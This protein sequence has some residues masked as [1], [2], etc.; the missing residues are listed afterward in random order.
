MKGKEAKGDLE[1]S[2]LFRTLRI[3]SFSL[4]SLE[5]LSVSLIYLFSLSFQDKRTKSAQ[6]F[7]VL[8]ITTQNHHFICLY[9]HSTA[10]SL[11]Y[12]YF[13]WAYHCL[14][15]AYMG[16]I[17]RKAHNPRPHLFY[18]SYSSPNDFAWERK[19]SLAGKSGKKICS[20]FG[21]LKQRDKL[22]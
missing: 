13:I 10:L 19:A 4:F 15:W 18:I 2:F 11:F 14:I 7:L 6:E 16:L 5:E 12:H 17:K 8:S 9:L 20:S 1:L 21:R 3:S 22:M